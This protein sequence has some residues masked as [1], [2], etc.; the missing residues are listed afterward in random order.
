[1]KKVLYL[2]L[3]VVF[4]FTYGCNTEELDQSDT[5]AD[6]KQLDLKGPIGVYNF[7]KDGNPVEIKKMTLDEFASMKAMKG[8]NSQSING[9]FT[10]QGGTTT[11]LSAMQNP[12]GAH[13][14]MLLKGSFGSTKLDVLCVWNE[15]NVGMAGGIISEKGYDVVDNFPFGPGDSI[16]FVYKDNG[17]GDKADSDQYVQAFFIVPLDAW[18]GAEPFGIC[19]FLPPPSFWDTFFTTPE[20]CGCEEPAGL[21]DVVN[22]GDQIQ[23][24]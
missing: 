14:N 19:E 9:H 22:K 2:L 15:E 7:D 1:M 6:S 18:Q 12:G 11:T 13:G 17:E 3:T 8:P 23:V 24:K 21:K 10:N 20:L 16:Y 5:S 4:I